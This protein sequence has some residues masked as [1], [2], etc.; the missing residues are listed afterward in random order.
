[1]ADLVTSFPVETVT[2]A[3]ELTV[4]F[5]VSDKLDQA[6]EAAERGRR[7][8]M[9]IEYHLVVGHF[10]CFAR[11]HDG[12]LRG[13]GMESHAVWNESDGLIG[14][15]QPVQAAR[16]LPVG[17]VDDDA[18]FV[19]NCL[20]SE[21]ACDLQLRFGAG[22]KLNARHDRTIVAGTDAPSGSGYSFPVLRALH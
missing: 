8:G 22:V 14:P 15:K 4:A 2:F 20:G 3:S 16:N 12:G 13:E 10:R 19:A 18:R 7:I 21:S 17:S 9:E 11:D 1:M 5:S 6:L